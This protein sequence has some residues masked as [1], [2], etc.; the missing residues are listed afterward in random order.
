M[1]SSQ[2]DLGFKAPHGS[3]GRSGRSGKDDEA[4]D[5]EPEAGEHVVPAEL[6]HQPVQRLLVGQHHGGDDAEPIASSRWPSMVAQK[7]DD[8][9][10]GLRREPDQIGPGVGDAQVAGE[11]EAGDDR[12]RGGHEPG[13]VQRARAGSRRPPRSARTG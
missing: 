4:G 8:D 13:Q 11:D 10:C 1:T 5:Q 7:A 12:D 9:R 6:G 3:T 2:S